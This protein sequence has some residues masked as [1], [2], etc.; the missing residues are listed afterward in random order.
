A[1]HVV[2]W[3]REFHRGRRAIA[4]A[5]IDE[6]AGPGRS[7]QLLRKLAPHRRRAEPFMQHNNGRRVRRGWTKHAVFE[8]GVVDAE[9]AGGGKGHA[10]YFSLRL[11]SLS[12]ASHSVIP[13]SSPKRADPE[14]RNCM[15]FEILRCAIAHHSSRL[16]RAPE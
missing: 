3:S 13:D 5:R 4:G 12:H 1:M 11:L 16:A 15:R 7:L 10:L 8:I 2:E 14:S 6:H 9:E